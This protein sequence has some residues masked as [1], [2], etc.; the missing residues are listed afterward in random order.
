[1]EDAEGRRTEEVTV[2]A[3]DTFLTLLGFANGAIGQVTFSWAGHGEP[4]GLPGGRAIYG[5]QGCLQEGQ[6]LRD[7]GFRG[8][9]RKV[10]DERA[11]AEVKEQFFPLGLTDHFALQKLDWLRAIET[12]GVTETNGEEGLE[13]LATSFAML[14]SSV[15]KR[16]VTV[17]EVAS[18]A[19]CEYQRE[20]DEY[21]GL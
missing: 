19:V 12:G 17:R 15:L 8:S 5:S 4:I 9:V 10:F 6:I 14:E 3:D 20:I 16:T 2:D 1:V 21:W 11:L 18:G 13:D 7:D